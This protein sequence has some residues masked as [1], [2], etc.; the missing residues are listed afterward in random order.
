MANEKN[1]N[2]VL[3]EIIAFRQGLTLRQTAK[4]L[5]VSIGF[6]HDVIKGRRNVTP[7]LAAKLGYRI[8]VTKTVDRKFFPL[9]SPNSAKNA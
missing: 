6:L 8:E 5:D 3:A 1:E 4:K 7:R 2:E 9:V